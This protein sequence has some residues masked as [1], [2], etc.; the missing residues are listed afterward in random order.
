MPTRQ[1]PLPTVLCALPSGN[2][3]GTHSLGRTGGV[4]GMAKAPTSRSAHPSIKMGGED[5]EW[6]DILYDNDDVGFRPVEPCAR[7]PRISRHKRRAPDVPDIVSEQ[8]DH[9]EPRS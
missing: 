1:Y 4:G 8:I 5:E 6:H 2:G 3:S 9:T 7:K